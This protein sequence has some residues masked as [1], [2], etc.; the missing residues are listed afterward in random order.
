M[1]VPVYILQAA[2]FQKRYGQVFE[3]NMEREN[4]SVQERARRGDMTISWN[5][6]TVSFLSI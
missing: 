3:R 4:G 5:A 6:A 1:E 2:W